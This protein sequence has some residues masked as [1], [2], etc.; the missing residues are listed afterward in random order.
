MN[1]T[2]ITMKSGSFKAYYGRCY[3]AFPAFEGWVCESAVS[4]AMPY[5]GAVCSGGT[6]PAAAYKQ[7]S[8]AY[9]S[10]LTLRMQQPREWGSLTHSAEESK[11]E[12]VCWE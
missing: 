9:C 4:A 8:T 6:V 3:F 12:S 11:R 2:E 1:F 5:S 7:V 10:S